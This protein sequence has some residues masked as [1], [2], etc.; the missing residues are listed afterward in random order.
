MLKNYAKRFPPA[1]IGDTVMVPIPDV[2]RGRAEFP[3]VKA[4]VIEVVIL[5]ANKN[6]Q[7]CLQAND[8][9]TY[10]LGTEHGRLK[11]LYT[12]NEFTPCIEKF[13]GVENVPA[14][15]ISLREAATAGAM[16]SGQGFVKCGCTKGC[17]KRSCKCYKNNIKC[18]SKCHTK[19]STCDNKTE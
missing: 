8:N 4:V 19:I 17:Q 2:D 9:A 1:A 11:Q 18:N 7:K 16:G 13:L 15:E 5:R 6:A 10:K 14:N 3:N 12:R